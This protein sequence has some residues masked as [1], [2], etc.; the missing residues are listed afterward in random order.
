M[1]DRMVIIMELTKVIK[2]INQKDIKNMDLLQKLKQLSSKESNNF[3]ARIIHYD[4]NSIFYEVTTTAATVIFFNEIYYPGW[5]M[6]CADKEL[7]LFRINHAFRGTY[8]EAGSYQ[9]KMVFLPLSFIVGLIISIC[10]FTF[11]F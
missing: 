5:H 3:S 4:P 10:C 7:P 2:V 9:L 11:M 1:Y 6:F 8:L